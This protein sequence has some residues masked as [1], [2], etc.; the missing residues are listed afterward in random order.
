MGREDLMSAAE[1]AADQFLRVTKQYLPHFA[2]LCLISTFLEDGIRM[3]FQW[4]EQR[5]YI[6]ATWSCGYFLA[7]GFVL[8]N[9]IGQIDGRLQ[10][11]VGSQVPHEEPGSRWRTAAA[12]GRVSLRGEEHVCRR[13]VDGTELSEA[14]H[15]AGRTCASG[16]HVHDAAALRLRLLLHPAEH[17]GHGAHRPGGR[18]LEDE[19]GRSDAGAV[20]PGHQRLLQRLLDG[21]FLQTH[22][23]LPEVRLLPDHVGDRRPAAG[24]GARPRRRLGGRE[25][26]AVVRRRSPGAHFIFSALLNPGVLFPLQQSRRSRLVSLWFCV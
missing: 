20:A 14:V 16:A 1:D 3:W 21:A 4:S 2:R 15:A 9:L 22:A 26:E 5:D 19:T 11:S 6:E 7:T 24:G 8:L 25:E 18:G 10:Y 17:G 13:A 23:R 12:A